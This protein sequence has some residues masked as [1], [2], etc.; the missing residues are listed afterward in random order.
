[1]WNTAR[2]FASLKVYDKAIPLM[3]QALELNGKVHGHDHP[4]TLLTMCSLSLLYRDQG[5]YDKA[6]EL[7]S[8]AFERSR[9]VLGSEHRVTLFTMAKF[10]VTLYE[11]G[12]LQSA[13]DLMEVFASKSLAVLGPT[14]PETV[15]RRQMAAAW[16]REL[17]EQEDVQNNAAKGARGSSDEAS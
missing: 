15:K 9:R 13:G 11:A 2:T 4:Y 5:S 1:M 12:R 16:R 7:G 17:E 3:A 6:I 10:A 8:E 14:H